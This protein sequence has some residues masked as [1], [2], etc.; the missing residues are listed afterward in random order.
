M[1]PSA[2]LGLRNCSLY[3]NWEN[4]SFKESYIVWTIQYQPSGW[5]DCNH[6]I[7][8]VSSKAI[9]RKAVKAQVAD[10]LVGIDSRSC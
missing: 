7:F 1:Y 8:Y 2:I 3:V 5:M 9:N 4:Y 10:G 6:N